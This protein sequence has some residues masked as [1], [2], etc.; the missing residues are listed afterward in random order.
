MNGDG[1][2]AASQVEQGEEDE[3]RSYAAELLYQ[4]GSWKRR[5]ATEWINFAR[6]ESAA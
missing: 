2:R 4:L 3:R 1:P 6:A 5:A